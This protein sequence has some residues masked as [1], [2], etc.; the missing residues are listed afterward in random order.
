[1][2]TISFSGKESILVRWINKNGEETYTVLSGFPYPMDDEG[3][4]QG[5]SIFFKNHIQSR[6]G[7][8]RLVAKTLNNIKISD[9][10]YESR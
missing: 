5:F 8:E 7:I 3:K 2:S 6:E 10:E 4:H 9:T 1:L